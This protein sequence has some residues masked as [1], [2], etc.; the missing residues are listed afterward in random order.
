MITTIAGILYEF[1]RLQAAK[2]DEE[3]L[4]HGPTIGSMYEGQTREI[5]DRSMPKELNLHVVE[6]FVEGPDGLLSPQIDAIL[7][8][9]SGREIPF[10]S[11]RVCPIRDVIA[12][13]EVKKRLYGD[14]LADA[15]DKM[16]RVSQISNE[17]V[18]VGGAAHIDLTPAFQ[19]FAMITGYYP[20]GWAAANSLPS[21]LSYMFHTL[22]SEYYAPS[23]SSSGITDTQRSMRYGK[24]SR[25]ISLRALNEAALA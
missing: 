8:V 6:G 24:P 13:L 17:F 22:V 23:A 5:L 4:T 16:R 14:G 15:I 1:M 21:P 25:I 7:T 18:E 3:P 11:S 2:L 12:V 19:T 10:S 20:R 9:G